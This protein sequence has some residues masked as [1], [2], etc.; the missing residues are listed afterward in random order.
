MMSSTIPSALML[1]NGS[2]AI[3]GMSGTGTATVPPIAA[4]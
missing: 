4:R 1:W 3:G 2:T